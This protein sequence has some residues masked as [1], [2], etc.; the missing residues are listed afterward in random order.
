[1]LVGMGVGTAADAVQSTIRKTPISGY[2]FPAGG[3]AGLLAGIYID[4]L[5]SKKS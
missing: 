3:A 1:M 5:R 4:H 2:G